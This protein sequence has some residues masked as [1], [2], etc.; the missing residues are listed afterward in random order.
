MT[1]ESLTWHSQ[2]I[3]TRQPALANLR[4]TDL[5]RATF[6]AN[7]FLQKSSLLFGM[8]A[9]LQLGWRCQKHP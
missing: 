6:E 9:N 7:F 3:I 2:T 5:S 8:Y 1:F 4:Q